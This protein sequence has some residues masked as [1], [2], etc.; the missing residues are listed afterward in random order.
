MQNAASLLTLL[1]L[2]SI[3]ALSAEK[4]ELH[5]R[6]QRAAAEFTDGI[7]WVRARSQ[8]DLAADGFRQDPYFYYYT[9]IENAV[10][11]ILAVVGKSGES[12]IFKRPD[13]TSPSEP[14]L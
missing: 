11:A 13:P 7:L 12:W 2:W 5:D 8:V 10:G 6:R 14:A 9:G 3:P 1:I 4:S